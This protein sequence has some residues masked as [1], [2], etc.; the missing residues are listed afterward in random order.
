M[1]KKKSDTPSQ[2]EGQ[3]NP[4]AAAYQWLTE[5]ERMCLRAF[6]PDDMIYDRARSRIAARARPL[7][8]SE[9]DADG[10]RV[11]LAGALDTWLARLEEPLT[12]E[13]ERKAEEQ[14]SKGCANRDLL[15]HRIGRQH[16]TK[17]WKACPTDSYQDGGAV[18]RRRLAAIGSEIAALG[19]LPEPS[20]HPWRRN[21]QERPD[22]AS[23]EKAADALAETLV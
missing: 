9:I 1:V 7:R 10:K 2:G 17:R 22:M 8:A 18:Y 5:V 13:Q 23:R 12:P 16:P 19:W 15:A 14:A 6:V 4:N 3:P 11:R 20:D 21:A